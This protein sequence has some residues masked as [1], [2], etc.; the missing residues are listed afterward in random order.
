MKARPSLFLPLL[1]LREGCLATIVETA[2]DGDSSHRVPSTD[3]E[4]MTFFPAQ[5][6]WF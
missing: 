4:T 6:V 5:S 1:L 2:Y 3:V